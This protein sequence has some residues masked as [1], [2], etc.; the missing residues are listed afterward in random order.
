MQAGIPLGALR[1]SPFR[2]RASERLEWMR[3]R[4]T[5]REEGTAYALLGLVDVYMPAMYGEGKENAIKRLL[6]EIEEAAKP[7]PMPVVDAAFN[8]YTDE[9]SARCHPNT[10]IDLLRQVAG[11]AEDPA[12]SLILGLNGMAGTGK[13][14]LSRTIAE[15]FHEHNALAASFFFKRGEAD[16]GNA[17]KFFTTLAAQLAKRLPRIAGHIRNAVEADPSPS[18]QRFAR[19]ISRTNPASTHLPARLA[20]ACNRRRCPRRVRPGRG[21]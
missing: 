10:R 20:D 4:Q 7:I 13:S 2:F 8:S 5:T 19:A 11:W 6:R 16:R 18:Q 17:A 9:H 15:R 21:H 14:T 3:D 1:S 12:G